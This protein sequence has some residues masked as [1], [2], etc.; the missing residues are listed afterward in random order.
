MIPEQ[1]LDRRISQ[2]VQARPEPRVADLAARARARA[3]TTEASLALLLRQRR[4]RHAANLA[5][6]VLIGLLLLTGGRP[7]LEPGLTAAPEEIPMLSAATGSLGEPEP[8]LSSAEL[9]L[10]GVM[11]LLGALMAATLSRALALETPL[12]TARFGTPF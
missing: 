8:T 11:M 9:M 4:W 5:A 2:A 12:P 7:L 6:A 3:Q 1:E 10:G